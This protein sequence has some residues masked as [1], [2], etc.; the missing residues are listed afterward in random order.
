MSKFDAMFPGVGT[1]F[2]D[3]DITK[4]MA[5]LAKTNNG[6]GKDLCKPNFWSGEIYLI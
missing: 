1:P 3:E 5:T 6:T 2:S 4:E